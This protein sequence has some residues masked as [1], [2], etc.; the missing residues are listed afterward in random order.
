MLHMP[1]ADAGRCR[2]HVPEAWSDVMPEADDAGSRQDMQTAAGMRPR[3]LDDPDVLIR[4]LTFCFLLNSA[5]G[6]YVN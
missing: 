6:Y 2:R 3:L 5:L 4:V 1:G